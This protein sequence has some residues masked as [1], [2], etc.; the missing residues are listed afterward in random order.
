MAVD[1]QVPIVPVIVWGAQRIATKGAPRNL[2]RS[3]TPI[4]VQFGDPIV[5]DTG[6]A[7]QARQLADQLRKRM[8]DLL[9]QVQE[10]YDEQPAGAYWVPARL[11][12]AAPTLA[13]ADALDVADAAAKREKR[14]DG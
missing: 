4:I 9:L 1:A 5:P 3:K 10:R 13:E 11:G 12:G 6:G 2:G 8:Q 7:V 14:Q